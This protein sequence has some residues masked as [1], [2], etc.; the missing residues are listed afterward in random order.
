GTDAVTTVTGYRGRSVQI[1]CPYTSGFEEHN[2]YL[3][4]GGC[5]Y[6]PGSKDIPVQS[7]SPAKG[8]RFSLYDD[9]TAKVFTVTITDLR[10]EDGGTYW[11]AIERT[12][13]NVY[14]EILLMVNEDDLAI[15]THP[16][17]TQVR[18]LSLHAENTHSAIDVPCISGYVMISIGGVLFAI[19]VVIGIYSKINYQGVPTTTIV[20]KSTYTNSSEH[21][22]KTNLTKG[23]PGYIIIGAGA[24]LFAVAVITAI[25]CKRNRRGSETVAQT[26]K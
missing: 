17:S 11:C 19:A 14:T 7:G 4:R 23:M 24:A 21:A 15:I 3:C 1:K 25:Y 20:S 8:S 2:K 5:P 12:G 26:T 9:T 18:G 16:T 10:P 6:W 13:C 22:G